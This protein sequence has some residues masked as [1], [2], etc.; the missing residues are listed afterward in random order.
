MDYRVM[1]DAWNDHSQTKEFV[2]LS[3]LVCPLFLHAWILSFEINW[4]M[5][6]NGWWSLMPSK[7]IKHQDL[8]LFQFLWKVDAPITILCARK[9]SHL[10]YNNEDTKHYTH[11][12]LMSLCFRPTNN[13]V[14]DYPIYFWILEGL[15]RYTPLNCSTFLQ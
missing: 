8:W 10:S 6:L 13:K 3:Q 15:W 5:S 9:M 1:Q 11:W 14:R 12:I 7:S 2:N 4:Q